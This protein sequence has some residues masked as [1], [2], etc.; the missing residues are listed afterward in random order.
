MHFYGKIYGLLI[1][2]YTSKRIDPWGKQ[3]KYHLASLPK[4]IKEVTSYKHQFP[5]LIPAVAK[6]LKFFFDKT[7]IFLCPSI[8]SS[9]VSLSHGIRNHRSRHKIYNPN[10]FQICRK[11]VMGIIETG[12]YHYRNNQIQYGAHGHVC[13]VG[14]RT[15]PRT[16]LDIFRLCT[17]EKGPKPVQLFR[18]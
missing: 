17:F 14:W 13:L 3:G 8:S 16:I 7:L 15:Y 1:F 5:L 12:E 2:S 10:S 4:D 11:M 9:V 6:F 18:N